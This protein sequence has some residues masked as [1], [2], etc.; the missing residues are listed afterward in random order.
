MNILI[1]TVSAG[2]GHINAAEAIKDRF[3][4]KYPDSNILLV[5]TYKYVNPLVD[6]VIVGSY[7]STIKKTPRIYGKLYALSESR[8]SKYNFGKKLNTLLAI[9]L[10]SLIDDFKPTIIVCTNFI[11]LQILSIINSKEAVNVP[12][13]SVITDFTTHSYW[14]HEYVSAYVVAHDFL[15]LELIKKGIPS[16]KI[17]PCGIPFCKS[18]LLNKD[19]SKL[20]KEFKLEEKLTVLIMGGGLGYGELKKTFLSILNMN[21]DIQIIVITGTNKKLKHQ[22][23][24]YSV[25]I[26]KKIKIVGYTNR[27]ADFMDISD[28]IITKPGG[29]T[30]TESLIKELPIFIIS[31]IPGQ[32]ERNARFLTNIG[33]SVRILKNDD[34][35]SILHQIMDN[36]LRVKQL[37]EMERFIARPKATDD[38]V[39]LIEM[40]ATKTNTED[41]KPS[42]NIPQYS[43]LKGNLIFE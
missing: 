26:N 24:N 39:N 18:F 21:K 34:A 40:L 22:L 29:M 32:E 31:P 13:I 17:Y 3:E 12:I 9:R 16:D 33:A 10:K 11:P 5:D 20:L 43:G 27:V 35:G 25:N 2:S 1:L 36:P 28:V 30:I 15:K 38:V 7:I 8:D 14:L 19:K 4:S 37:K 23:E 42:I 6:K 41:I